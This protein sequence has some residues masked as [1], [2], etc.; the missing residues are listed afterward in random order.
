MLLVSVSAPGSEARQFRV[1]SAALDTAAGAVLVADSAVPKGAE[2]VVTK[3]APS[4]VNASG[5]RLKNSG[6]TT[7]QLVVGSLQTTIDACVAHDLPVTFLLGTPFIQKFVDLIQ[8]RERKFTLRDPDTN[9]RCSVYL[10][11]SMLSDPQK[12]RGLVGQS[13]SRSVCTPHDGTV[14]PSSIGAFWF[15]GHSPLSPPS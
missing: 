11:T 6:H 3:D 8:P 4:L 12:P 9:E 5:R 10:E 7:L 1:V 13:S 14:H 15:V 2:V